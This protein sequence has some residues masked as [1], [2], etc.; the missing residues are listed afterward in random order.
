MSDLSGTIQ[1]TKTKGHKMSH[2]L[3]NKIYQGTLFIWKNENYLINEISI[4]N[5]DK[6]IVNAILVSAKGELIGLSC[7]IA[8]FQEGVGD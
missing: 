4:V 1:L 7:T 8:E 5:E 3:V 2:G 6:D